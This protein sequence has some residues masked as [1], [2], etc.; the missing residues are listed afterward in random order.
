MSSS[1]LPPDSEIYWIEEH[2]YRAWDR[3]AETNYWEYS[4]TYHYKDGTK[5]ATHTCPNH[6]LHLITKEPPSAEDQTEG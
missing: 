3:A 1:P 2:W 4:Y 5:Y 6:L